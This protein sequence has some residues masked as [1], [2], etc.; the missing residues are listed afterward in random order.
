MYNS[1]L[2]NLTEDDIKKIVVRKITIGILLLGLSIGW[3][4]YVAMDFQFQWRGY[5]EL[6]QNFWPVFSGKHSHEVAIAVGKSFNI[7]YL[8]LFFVKSIFLQTPYVR[9]VIDILKWMFCVAFPWATLYWIFLYVK[10]LFVVFYNKSKSNSITMNV[11]MWDGEKCE[12]RYSLI[13]RE[14]IVFDV[15]HKLGGI[16]LWSWISVILVTAFFPDLGILIIYGSNDTCTPTALN[17]CEATMIGMGLAYI[18]ICL[19]R[20]LAALLIGAGMVAMT[21]KGTGKEVKHV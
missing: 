11:R 9:Y 7:Q 14:S 13:D 1:Y 17:H 15:F 21:Y 4:G 16:V 5:L 10:S 20:P 18:L 12:F 3:W 2:K 6:L 8:W 19:L